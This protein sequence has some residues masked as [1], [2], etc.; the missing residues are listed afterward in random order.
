[1][2]G[3]EAL[4]PAE[5]TTAMSELAGGVAVIC[6][7]DED[8]DVGMTSTT[9]CSISAEPP[10]VSL[11]VSVESY[12][13]ELLE[14]QPRWAVTILSSGQRTVAS[15]FAAAGRPSARLLLTDLPHHRGPVSGGL[16]ADGGVAAL[17]CETVR[18]IPAGDHT[19]VLARALAVDYLGQDDPLLYV[20][21]RYRGV[22]G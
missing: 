3:V 18:R 22:D 5:F 13:D 15:R 16:I 19:L 6:V 2:I 7:R 17:E 11:A 20:R 14:R 4:T 10:L 1:V 21:R 12:V 9:F 8:D